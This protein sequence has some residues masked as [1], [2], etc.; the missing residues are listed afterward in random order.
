MTSL[1]WTKKLSVGNEIIDAEHRNLIGMVGDVVR[2]I[3]ARDCQTLAHAFE[4]LEG[5]LFVHFANEEKI[6]QAVNFDFANHKPAQQY[7]LQELRAIRNGLI[8]RNGIWSDETVDYFAR[9]L[10][11]WIIDGHIVNLDMQMKPALLVHDYKFYPGRCDDEADYA[12]KAGCE[13][14]PVNSSADLYASNIPTSAVSE[15]VSPG[16]RPFLALGRVVNGLAA[17][18]KRLYNRWLNYHF[19]GGLA[20]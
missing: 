13:S 5:W 6:A 4:Q 9:A 2:A 10:K 8:A 20:K 15:P 11:E 12:A 16:A 1:M 7:S 18:F 14:A 19:L 17:A 3:R